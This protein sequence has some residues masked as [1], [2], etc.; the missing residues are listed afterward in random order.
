MVTTPPG[1]ITTS[2]LKLNSSKDHLHILI[3]EIQKA[4]ASRCVSFDL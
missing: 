1:D 2:T 4:G 3:A